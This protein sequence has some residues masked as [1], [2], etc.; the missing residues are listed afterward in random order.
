MVCPLNLPVIDECYGL[1][2]CDLGLLASFIEVA[3]PLKK[4]L[5][6]AVNDILEVKPVVLSIPIDERNMPDMGY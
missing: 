3:M 4:F 6:H 1:R 5:A 2:T